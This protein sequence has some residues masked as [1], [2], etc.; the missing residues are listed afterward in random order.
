MNRTNIV[1]LGIA[2]NGLFLYRSKLFGGITQ[3]VVRIF[4]HSNLMDKLKGTETPVLFGYL[5]FSH[6]RNAAHSVVPKDGPAPG[7]KIAVAD[8]AYLKATGEWE[9]RLYLPMKLPENGDN[10]RV[11]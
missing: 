11:R 5:N 9:G 10:P 7:V 6:S 1:F 3:K 8:S 4:N 2:P